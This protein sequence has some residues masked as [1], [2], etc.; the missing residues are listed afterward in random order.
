MAALT[1]RIQVSQFGQRK[2]LR[3]QSHAAR[4]AP[5]CARISAASVRCQNVK[6]ETAA[7]SSSVSRRTLVS[8]LAAAAPALYAAQALALI[9][10]DEDN[11][12]LE[13]IRSDRKNKLSAEL[14]AERDTT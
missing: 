12:L 13:K 7:S 9:D 8:S 4:K 11:A 3:S 14:K 2:E 10:Y 6:D 5:A 1:A